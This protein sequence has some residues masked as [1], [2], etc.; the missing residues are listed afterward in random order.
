M[1]L[2]FQC[3]QAQ[4]MPLPDVNA[5][6]VLFLKFSKQLNGINAFGEVLIVSDEENAEWQD[7]FSFASQDNI[8]RTINATFY[9]IDKDFFGY[10]DPNV[11]N[12]VILT[13]LELK[14]I[15]ENKTEIQRNTYLKSFSHIYVIDM[16]SPNPRQTFKY[17]M[18]EVK[19]YF[20]WEH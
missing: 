12:S 14:G 17:K 11:Y 4:Q 9:T 15:L 6:N 10:T 18:L 16:D 2:G 8:G 1:L 5:S 19:P 13:E 7:A 3:I 20:R